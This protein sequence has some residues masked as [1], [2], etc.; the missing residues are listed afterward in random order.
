M[1]AITGSL[2]DGVAQAP[3]LVG[4]A[5]HAGPCQLS[6]DRSLFAPMCRASFR[7]HGGG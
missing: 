6:A 7:H 5:E 3:E 4:F 2:L 1:A